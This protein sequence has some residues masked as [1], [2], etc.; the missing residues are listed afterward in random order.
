LKTEW[1]HPTG[2][3]SILP[4]QGAKIQQDYRQITR[5]NGFFGNFL[6]PLPY[7]LDMPL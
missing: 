6:T 3:K 1:N 5:K 7:Q 4:P 2:G